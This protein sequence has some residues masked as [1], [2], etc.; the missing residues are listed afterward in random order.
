MATTWDETFADRYEEWSAGMTTDVAF[1]VNLAGEADGPLVELAIGNGRVAIPVAQA[2][3]KL[4]LESTCH[5]AC[6][7]KLRLARPRRVC[8]SACAKVTCASWPS[9]SQQP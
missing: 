7:Y 8:I 4:S 3:A 1:Y 9:M 2:T 5:R 6:S